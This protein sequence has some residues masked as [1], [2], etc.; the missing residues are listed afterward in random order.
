[1][2]SSAAGSP[3]RVCWP[4]ATSPRRWRRGP[5]TWRSCPVRRSASKAARRWTAGRS[6]DCRPKRRS[7]WRWL[8]R[9]TTCLRSPSGAT[10]GAA[11]A[12]EVRQL[13]LFP[14]EPADAVA[15][16]R[17]T[18]RPLSA[19]FN[20][21]PAQLSPLGNARHTID[22][23]GRDLDQLVAALGDRP[24]G[25]GGSGDLERFVAQLQVERANQAAS[26]RRKVAMLKT[27][28]RYARRAG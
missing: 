18:E 24:L 19:V 1:M 4:G 25:T 11:M 17:P 5:P 16:P 20:W 9:P 10:V 26:L 12:D 15:P 22:S 28:F 14:T 27:F 6:S 2:S 21:V 23:A 3:S 7:S 13:T 8:E